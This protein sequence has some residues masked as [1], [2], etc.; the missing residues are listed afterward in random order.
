MASPPTSP[1]AP[2]TLHPL[3]QY[4]QNNVLPGHCTPLLWDLREAPMMSV[5]HVSTPHIALTEQ[6]LSQ[7]ATTPRVPYLNISCGILPE[8]WA[9]TAHNPQGVTLLD[10][11]Q[12]IYACLQV[13][14]THAEWDAM[15]LKHQN[16]ISAVF[17]LRWR[18]AA[19]PATTHAQGVLRADC[20]LNH[21]LFGGLALSLVAADSCVLTLRRPYP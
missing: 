18:L 20:L 5:R 3:L 16:R 1:H 17:D 9:M 6:D 7:H 4:V 11:F 19:A 21:I 10:V 8:Q 2:R 15:C 12:T 14:L 13:Q